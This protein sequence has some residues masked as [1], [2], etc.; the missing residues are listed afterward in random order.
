[1]S[2]RNSRQAAQEIGIFRAFLKACPS[3]ARET[4][5]ITQP[6]QPFPDITAKLQ[7]GSEIDFELGEWLDGQQMQQAK[8]IERLESSLL[9]ALGEQG[10]SK[11][12]HFRCVMLVLRDDALRFDPRHGAAFR[13]ELLTLIAETDH[14]WP[15][16]RYWHS[17][18]GRVCREL[19]SYPGL[20]KYLRSVHFSPL[21]FGNT[22]AERWPAGQPWIFFRSWGGSYSSDTALSA[23]FGIIQ[24]KQ[25]HY[26]Y[27]D[28]RPVRLLVY[29]GQA[30]RYNTPYYGI[31]TREF[32]DVAAWSAGILAGERL[33]FE[34]V[35]LLQALEPNLQAFEIYPSFWMCQ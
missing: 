9:D 27:Q 17:P 32:E 5:D 19:R 12:N 31:K 23:L 20:A 3:L 4:V 29:Y 1:V 2:C 24:K 28:S 34:K 6:C 26:G 16:E 22:T 7:A 13:S 30:V 14:R 10:T 21:R 18:Q 33:I 35:Y 25:S 8:K 15:S 11:S